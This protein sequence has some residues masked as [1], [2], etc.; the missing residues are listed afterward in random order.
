MPKYL[1]GILRESQAA[2][3]TI[4]IRGAEVTTVV[5]GGLAAAV[6]ESPRLRPDSIPRA[7]L[8]P[9]IALHQAVLARISASRPILPV[10]FGT[11]AEGEAEIGA[12]LEMGRPLLIPALDRAQEKV[13]VDVVALWADLNA[14]LRRVAAQDGLGRSPEG[15]AGLSSEK[16]VAVKVEL[17]RL[18]QAALRGRSERLKEEILAFLKDSA[19][20]HKPREVMD[21]SMI[22]NAAFWLDRR[23]EPLFE[24]RLRDLEAHHRGRV[25]F[26]R[27]GPLPPYSFMMAEVRRLEP[28]ALDGAWRLFGLN[29]G[30]GSS[31]VQNR[32][33]DLARECHPDRRPG[34]AGASR[35]FEE[36]TAAYRTLLEYRLM[37]GAL[38]VALSGA[39]GP[40][41]RP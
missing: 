38:G 34:D 29:G 18:L 39:V 24:S 7:Q 2:F 23:S 31:E 5:H 25:V 12:I 21:D 16:L 3:G 22:L 10:K 27:E 36:L 11:T 13:E 26:K 6:S 9:L 17:G 1:Y 14:E 33:R 19:E 15:L 32:Y 30:A 20:D 37:G 8:L 28:E 41:G 40:G 4:G 35:R